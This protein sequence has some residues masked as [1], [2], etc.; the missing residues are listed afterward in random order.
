MSNLDD[1]SN[2]EL[3]RLTLQAD[4]AH[5]RAMLQRVF[6]F[7]GRFVVYP[8]ENTQVAHALWVLHT[9]LMDCW[10]TTPRIAFLSAEPA[11][12]KSRA[13]EITE[14]L[15]PMP[16]MAV[17]MSPA[18]I[19]RK[20]GAGEGA[21]ILYDEIDTVFG[22]KAKE[23]EEI[24]ALLNAGH[25][26]GAVAGRC[27]V[28]GKTVSTE[29]IPAYA[30]VAVAGLGWL[31]DTILTRA[32]IVRMRR[33]K[34]DEQIEPF[35]RRMVAPEAILIRDQI[36]RWARGIPAEIDWPKMP[37]YI[38]DR[39]ADVWEP[40]LAVADLIGGDWPYRARQAAKALLEAAK[41]AE[42]SFGVLLLTHLKMVFG[43]A[44]KMPTERILEKLHAIEEAPWS[45]LR[46]KP[47]DSRGLARLL[48]EYGIKSRVLRINETTVRGYQ[49]NDFADAWS[50]YIPPLATA[51]SVTSATS[52]TFIGDQDVTGA[53][54]GDAVS[55]VSP[56]THVTH[57][58]GNGGKADLAGDNYPGH[59]GLHACTLEEPESSPARTSVP[60][61]T[62]AGDPWAD[63]GI[64]PFLDRI[65]PPRL[66][67]P[68]ISAGPDD[69]LGDFH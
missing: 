5:G 10:E 60:P 34:S 6:E 3:D 38:Q 64:P 63:L 31:P 22:P 30:A 44:D 4:T 13:L 46:G 32:V 62:L 35:R 51:T 47:L 56:V 26:R 25:R 1:L 20:V 45:D 36:E 29:E 65:R 2:R 41:D 37:S 8:S 16:V 52:V 66:G 14:L 40:L 23:N 27:V 68:A 18:Y 9:H 59:S 7:I 21:T 28:H 49:R 48:R 19:F 53:L 15:V 42:P 33:R 43:E 58:P 11:S 17:N 61:L 55:P 69:D 67:P 12:G 54:N 50:R 39:D 24:R 57:F